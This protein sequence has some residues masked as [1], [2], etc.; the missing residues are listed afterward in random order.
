VATRPALHLTR[1]GSKSGLPWRVRPHLT[2]IDC[3]I[4]AIQ[5]T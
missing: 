5:F 3:A 2:W 4:R 1:S